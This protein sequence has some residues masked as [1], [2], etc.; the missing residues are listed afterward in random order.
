M[1][2]KRGETLQVGKSEGGE[3]KWSGMD[4]GIGNDVWHS[5][6]VSGSLPN[7]GA[8]EGVEEAGDS[9]R[10]VDQETTSRLPRLHG[11]IRILPPPLFPH[12]FQVPL[13][14]AHIQDEPTFL[15]RSNA[16]S[17]VQ[18]PPWAGGREQHRAGRNM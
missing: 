15:C 8:K 11:A 18:I 1:T 2:G 7:T 14:S 17:A 12:C 3:R 5:S 10:S 13:K 16:A 6:D 4:W 9:G